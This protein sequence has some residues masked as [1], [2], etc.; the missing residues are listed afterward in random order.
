[1]GTRNVRRSADPR[2]SSEVASTPESR[3]APPVARVVISAYCVPKAGSVVA[4]RFAEPS[5]PPLAVHP[6]PV[7]KVVTTALG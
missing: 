4:F 5:P 2:K 7:A 6:C 3:I 1:M